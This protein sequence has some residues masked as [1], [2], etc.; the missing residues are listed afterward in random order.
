MK[1]KIIK[2]CVEELY[3]ESLKSFIEFC[4][5]NI[6]T[7]RGEKLLKKS[8]EV[9]ERFCKECVLKIVLTPFGGN[10]VNKDFFAIKDKAIYCNELHKN[11]S[12]KIVGGYMYAIFIEPIDYNNMTTLE[13]YYAD[14]W[15]SSYVEAGWKNINSILINESIKDFSVKEDKDK[16]LVS[17]SFAPGFG[18]M[19]IE[20]I[21]DLFELMNLQEYGMKLQDTTNIIPCNSIIGIYLMHLK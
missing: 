5:I 2:I 9:R 21:A 1:N 7:V 6:D 19:Q 18:G 13:M 14:C 10:S 16:L 20:S 11:I 12:D 8:L 17:E 3:E 15:L 4:K